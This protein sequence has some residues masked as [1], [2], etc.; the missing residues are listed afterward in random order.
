VTSDLNRRLLSRLTAN[1]LSLTDD[2]L[3][4]VE[5]YFQ[6]LSFWNKKI[7]L[8]GFDLYEPT[9]RAIDR[10]IC[11]PIAAESHFPSGALAWL[12]VGSGGGSPAIPIKIVR[13]QS[14]LTMV[15][16]RGRKAAFLREACRE[17]DLSQVAVRDRRFQ[18][19]ASEPSFQHSVSV[20]TIRAVRGDLS[21]VDGVRRMLRQ[22]GSVLLFGQADS[23][24]WPGFGTRTVS[25]GPASGLSF[26]S[27]LSPL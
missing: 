2:K 20:I 15:E 13:P 10:L 22:D 16:M 5:A 19:L 11:E 25:L 21:I 27:I 18:D 26:L 17:L 8:T 3:A 9:D 24:D 6:L 23:M 12:D 1:R 7:N 14:P 4:R